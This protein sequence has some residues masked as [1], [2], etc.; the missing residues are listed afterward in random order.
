LIGA[1]LYGQRPSLVGQSEQEALKA[2][3]ERTAGQ[4]PTSDGSQ[5]VN[6]EYERLLRLSNALDHDGQITLATKLLSENASIRGEW[7]PK[8]KYLLVDEYQ[9][10]NPA[11]FEFIQ[12]LS[13]ANPQGLFVVGDDDQSIYG[14][15]GGSPYFIREFA[16]HFGS[17]AVTIQMKTS[18]RC[19]KEILNTANALVEKYD[20][21]RF[22]K[23][24]P[25]FLDLEA[26]EVFIHDCPSDD[27]EA[28]LIALIIR[29][30]I[31][32]NIKDA[33]QAF[34]LIPNR[35]YSKKLEIALTA[36]E[37]GYTIRQSESRSISM[38]QLVRS[39]IKEPE[40]NLL[41]R[42][43][44]QLLIESGETLIPSGKSKKA[45]KL[46]ART[47]GLLTIAHLWNE[48]SD[49]Q[50]TLWNALEQKAETDDAC[51]DL[52]DKMLE[53]RNAYEDDFAE[54]LKCVASY[55]KPWPG[56]A[57]FYDEL[58]GID[59]SRNRPPQVG[60]HS[61]RIMTAQ[62]SKGLE[63]HTVFIIGLEEGKLPSSEAADTIAEESRLLFVAMTRAITK[64]HLL[65]ARTRTS[66]ISLRNKSY[67][68][69]P[70]RFIASILVPKKNRIYH[71][72]K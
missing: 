50:G 19:K 23:A 30:E 8:T 72:P 62:N 45:D 11:E 15:R 46:K 69:K 4:K 26:G 17:G 31:R 16:K 64:L 65:H 9:D 58:E 44:I 57:A 48:T 56:R 3:G 38:F 29:D 22:P 59:R 52:R 10:I 55:I 70:S 49:K 12:L 20:K 53:L 34:I 71:P 18:R 68:L 40:L 27:R 28:S 41:T 61:V 7:L 54:F 33:R 25:E 1:F 24:T 36:Q 37:I 66:S 21:Q 6:E 47:A 2:Y 13:Q 35:N 5:K 63:A 39:W 60:A 67:Q 42:E 14:F 43:I 51:K 32:E